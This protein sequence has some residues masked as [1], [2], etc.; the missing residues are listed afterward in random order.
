MNLATLGG[1]LIAAAIAIATKPFFF[2][3]RT[4]EPRRVPPG[5][6]VAHIAANDEVSI[7]PTILKSRPE[8]Q[9]I[10][11]GSR[12]MKHPDGMRTVVAPLYAELPEDV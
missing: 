2:P 11:D 4:R 7:T 5:F 12:W 9:A 10:V 8:A 3:P 6:V 1:I